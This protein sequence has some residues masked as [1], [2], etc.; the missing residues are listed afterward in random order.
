MVKKSALLSILSLLL[1]FASSCTTEPE[2]TFV[3]TWK[4]N[5]LTADGLVMTNCIITL[6]SN[7]SFLLTYD[8]SG[9]NTQSGSFA[10]T[11]LP[12]NTSITFS[13]TASSGLA[14]PPPPATWFLRQTN[15]TATTMDIEIDLSPPDGFDDPPA[16]FTRQ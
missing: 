6:N 2:I 14:A 13:V 1:I 5:S 8:A 7:A 10:P 11:D 9:A 4:A 12:A 15:L 3:G 16:T